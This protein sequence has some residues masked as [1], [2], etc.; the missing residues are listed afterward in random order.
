ME[1]RV[2]HKRYYLIF[3]STIIGPLSTN[4]L[5]PLFEELR[6][7]FG[8]SVIALVALAISFYIFPFAI[9]QL[10]AGT[11]SDVVDKKKVVVFGYII[12]I[13]GLLTSLSAVFLRNYYLF[14]FAFLIQGIGF[15]FINPIILA[16]LNVVTPDKKKGFIFGIYNSSAGIGITLG[17]FLSGF[18]IN[19]FSNEWRFL[20]VINPLVAAISLI[21]F[22]IALRNCEPLVCKT[23]EI[24]EDHIEGGKQKSSKIGAT[25]QKL[26]EGFCI[27][28]VLLGIIGFICF[29]SVI[30]LVNTLNEQLRFTIR[31]LSD[32][33][34][35]FYV[36]LILTIC[37]ITSIIVSPIIGLLLKRVNPFIFLFIG[38]SIMLIMILMPFGNTINDFIIISFLTYLGSAFIWPS[39]FKISMNLDPEKSGTNSAI[40]NSFR[41]TGYALVGPIYLFFGIPMIFYIVF[42]FNLIALSIIIVVRKLLREK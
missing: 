25:L 21:L 29:F 35:I 5:I 18:L 6:I 19:F 4:F 12:F 26:R 41:F 16:I 22:L 11:F 3:F 14:L 32:R 15:A 8:L 42:C 28:I 33:E 13:L 20:F 40:I 1:E 37:G 7:N 34:I 36:S 39:L 24:N 23:F 38:F 2:F 9:A 31:D 27:E 10:F 17:A 30:T